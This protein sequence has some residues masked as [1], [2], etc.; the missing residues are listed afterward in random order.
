MSTTVT[1]NFL[2]LA[3]TWAS[4]SQEPC[5]IHHSCSFCDN[6]DS[7]ACDQLINSYREN[8][9]SLQ[10]ITR[11]GASLSYQCGLGKAFRQP[12]GHTVATLEMSC[13][14][15]AAWM[16]SANMLDCVC[17]DKKVIRIDRHFI[18]LA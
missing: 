12:S 14:W 17:K 4:G 9:T 18:G 2:N 3:V 11:Y 13:G 7:A 1:S 8:A 16:P 6:D 15:E 10:T 5:L